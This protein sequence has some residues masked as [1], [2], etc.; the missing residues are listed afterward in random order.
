MIEAI[1]IINLA[2]SSKTD[3][4]ANPQLR[5]QII[6]NREERALSIVQQSKQHGF[7]VRFWEGITDD[8]LF[9]CRNI[10]RAFKKIVSYAREERLPF[11]TIG[12]D[13][14]LLTSTTAWAYYQQHIPEDYDLYLGGIYAGRIDGNRVTDGYSGHTL[15]TVHER[16][17]DFFLSANEDEHLDRW[18]GKFCREKI[19]AVTTPFVIK[20]LGGYSESHKRMQNYQAY[21]QDWAYL[22]D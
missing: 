4:Y 9:P 6:R 7:S 16:F 5:Q 14:M 17:Y 13:D 12:E 22:A 20:Q 11:I 8:E 15:I 18:L 1:H 21:E 10:S 3:K 19:Y 2:A